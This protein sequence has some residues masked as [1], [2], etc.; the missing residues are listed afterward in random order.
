[1]DRT[2]ELRDWAVMVPFQCANPAS[3]MPPSQVEPL[4]VF[5]YPE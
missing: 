3:W 4:P 1:M 2:S 5:Q